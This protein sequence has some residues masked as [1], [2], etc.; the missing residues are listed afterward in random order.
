[1]FCRNCGK[2][3]DDNAVVCPYCGIQTVAGFQI[4]QTYQ[5]NLHYAAQPAEQ[6]PNRVNGLGIAGFVVSILSIWLGIY[7]CIFSFVA[8]GLSIGGMVSMKK[9]GKCNGLAIAGL[10]ISI[11][12]TAFWCFIWFIGFI[13]AFSL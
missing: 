5:D 2:E 13:I 10:V 6:K 7:L 8:L 1:M 12:T 9:C 3:I 4:P 11:L